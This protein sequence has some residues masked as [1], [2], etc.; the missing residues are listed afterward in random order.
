M[1]ILYSTVPYEPA[2]LVETVVLTE[3]NVHGNEL[4]PVASYPAYFIGHC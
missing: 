4:F 2:T 3:N 1:D